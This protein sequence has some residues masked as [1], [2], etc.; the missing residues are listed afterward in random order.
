MYLK[1]KIYLRVIFLLLLTLSAF[2]LLPSVSMAKSQVIAKGYCG[3]KSY[4]TEEKR[5]DLKWELRENGTMV[6]SGKGNMVDC[7]EDTLRN[8]DYMRKIKKVVSFE[9]KFL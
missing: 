6:I 2:I 3:E 9:R 8:W 7:P 5:T 1:G 4:I